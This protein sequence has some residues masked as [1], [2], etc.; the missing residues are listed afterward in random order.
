MINLFSVYVPFRDNSFVL[1]DGFNVR[2]Y[3][4]LYHAERSQGNKVVLAY[5]STDD[6]IKT[7]MDLRSFSQSFDISTKSMLLPVELLRDYHGRTFSEV[8]LKVVDN[9]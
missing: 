5:F 9:A 6:L 4:S 8:D 7:G 2:A 1:T 3:M